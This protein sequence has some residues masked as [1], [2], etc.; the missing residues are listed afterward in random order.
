MSD[1]KTSGFSRLSHSINEPKLSPH[2][3]SSINKHLEPQTNPIVTLKCAVHNNVG[4][5][6]SRLWND[7]ARKGYHRLQQARKDMETPSYRIEWGNIAADCRSNLIFYLKNWKCL[8]REILCGIAATLLQIPETIAFSY[9][10]NLD[11]IIGLHATGIFAIV[12]SLFGGVPGTI[13]GAAGA[14]AVVMPQ[15]T[16]SSGDLKEYSYSVRL[17]HLYVA[18][19]LA[20]IMQFLFGVFH[21]SKFFSM[22]P[23][24]AHI[25]FLNGL[26]IMM[27]KSQSTT[28]KTCKSSSSGSERLFAKCEVANELEW[29][30]ITDLHLVTTLFT[31]LATMCIM[32][33]FPKIPKIGSL[34]PPT[35]IVAVFG[36]GFEF[37]INRPL[38]KYDV[39]TIGDTSSISG[40]FPSFHTP[41]LQTVHN[42]SAVISCAASLAAIGIFESIMTLQA[43]VDLRKSRLNLQ[44]CR[45]ESIAQGVGNIICSFFH[46]MGGCSMI[47]QSTGNIINGAE[48]R[49]S[50]FMCGI[51]TFM[52]VCF[53]SPIMEL[54]PVA[55]LSGILFVIIAHTFHWKSL[56]LIFHLRLCDGFTIILVTVLAATL[57]LAVAVIAGVIWHSLVNGWDTGKQLSCREEDIPLD[58]FLSQ[59]TQSEE[60]EDLRAQGNKDSLPSF[61]KVYHVQGTLLY[62]S[63]MRLRSFFHSISQDPALVILDISQCHLSDFSASAALQEVATLYYDQHK[64]MLLVHFADVESFDLVANKD[65]GWNVLRSHSDLV[66]A[67]RADVDQ[68]QDVY[69]EMKSPHGGSESY[70]LTK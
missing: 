57:N 20:G 51:T 40:G 67:L 59:L 2:D 53:A 50:G 10:A 24:T 14:L 18:V 47:A 11:P 33:F 44:A 66:Q 60:I 17:S 3:S 48:Y 70:L 6:W 23:R 36:I 4:S 25:G 49:L 63:V 31:V 54:V 39:R 43:I 64:L 37:G 68:G 1:N 45:K 35:L 22:I 61:I 8:Q 69:A 21:L 9:V 7:T 65:I 27:L 52:I 13:A 12:I 16:G 46:G 19:L 32:Q 62:S 42:W 28:F 29:M 26:A 5:L 41:Q 56:I 38:F 34:I 55:C 15:L 58:Q 30:H